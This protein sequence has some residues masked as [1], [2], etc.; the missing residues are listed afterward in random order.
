MAI[1]RFTVFFIVVLMGIILLSK[2]TKETKG[3]LKYDETKLLLD[4]GDVV[5]AKFGKSY[6]GNSNRPILVYGIVTDIDD[7]NKGYIILECEK[8]VI[9]LSPRIITKMLKLKNRISDENP[10]CYAK[11]NT[12]NT[13]ENTKE[14]IKLDIV[15]YL[16]I[17]DTD[18]T[19]T[20]LEGNNN[21]CIENTMISYNRL[22]N[23]IKNITKA[24]L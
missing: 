19:Y 1:E 17:Y 15:F 7:A 8:T 4:Y 3:V 22:S 12:E 10:T 13:K 5:L 2:R 14:N 24:T 20:I 11:E 18:R 6:I 16:Y 9:Y 23:I 21:N